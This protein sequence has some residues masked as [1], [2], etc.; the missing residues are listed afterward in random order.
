MNHY[1][2]FVQISH[3]FIFPAFF[4]RQFHN[5]TYIIFRH[6][7]GCI[8]IRFFH[9][10][11]NGRVRKVW[12]IVYQFYITISAEN[13]INYVRRSCNQR[14]IIFAFQT[15]FNNVHV[16]KP[17]KAAAEAKAKRYWSFRFKYQRSIIKLQFFQRIA[18]IIIIG[19]FYRIQAAVYHRS[20]LAV[21]G[22]RT[23]CRIVGVSNCIADTCVFNIFNS[24]GQ[25]SYLPCIQFVYN[26]RVRLKHADFGNFKFCAGSHHTDFHA[27]F[28]QP[29]HYA[30]VK[31]NAFISV[32]F[33][34]KYQSFKRFFSIAARGRNF[35]N[36][37]FQYVFNTNAGFSA[38][39]HS[40]WGIDADNVLN[41]VLDTFRV[42]TR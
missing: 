27:F 20:G 7:N 41:F 5:C 31:H 30:E 13:F 10:V 8:Y 11:N 3:V 32:K 19:I 15:F 24:S 12:R 36:N 23:F 37:S 2:G 28:Y 29:V 6:D 22:Q 33:W 9:V 18:Q 26:Y 16:Q 4:L 1:A 42:C 35:S 25:K 38:C 17:Q 14:Q 34:I 21:A 40:F 39:K